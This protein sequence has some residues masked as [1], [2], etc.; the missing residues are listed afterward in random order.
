MKKFGTMRAAPIAL[1]LTVATPAGAEC[2]NLCDY[3]WWKT[4]TTA[5]VQA[6]LDGDADVMARNKLSYTPL[7]AAARYGSP[8]TVQ[9]LLDA[10]ADARAKDDGD[11][12]PWDYAQ[13]NEKLKNTKAFWA[14]NDAQ[15]N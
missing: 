4:A 8:A 13:N 15:Y 11:K 12:T 9:D 1:M 7:H 14:L 10:G 2:G 3:N 6:E 5:D